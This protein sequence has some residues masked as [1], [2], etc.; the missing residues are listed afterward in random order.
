MIRGAAIELFRWWRAEM[1]GIGRALVRL[2]PSRRSPQLLL[3]VG[4]D[5]ASLEQLEGKNW[6]VIGVVPR[7]DDGTWSGELPGL[8]P[9]LR[10]AR[11]AIVLPADEFYFEDFELPAAAVR[12]LRAVL[13]LQLEHRLPVSLDL[14]LVDHE[15]VGRDK[16]RET[17]HV[18]CAVAHREV[19]ESWRDRAA[20]WG[21][22]AV[23]VGPPSEEGAPA[24]NLLKRRRDP[25]R[26]A[27]SPLD[28]KLLRFAAI[29]AG[30][31]FVL[32]GIQWARER[33]SVSSQT[34]ELHA[35]A[36]KLEAQR[37]ALTTRA[38]PLV[39]LR[40]IAANPDA[41]RLLARLST[42]VPTSAWF[43]HVDLTMPI[44]GAGSVK[45]IG[46]IPSQEEVVAALSAM[47][48]MR[49]LRSSSTF[50]GNFLG[51]DRVEITAE[52]QPQ[53]VDSP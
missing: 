46:A 33:A 10:H 36:E 8:A 21:L 14:L 45:L 44:E 20:G 9:A 24:L 34:V 35:Q 19:V 39:A 23:S 17:L 3:R 42:A 37:V 4:V 5:A 52:Y 27:P 51:R 38:A 12:H 40:T 13:H 16:H 30:L 22:S 28:W 53:R 18:R 48:G 32:V 41:P 1:R 43:T 7:R 15:L 49:N 6:N 25:I 47:P 31:C 26:W 50:N 2:L 29:G 11:T